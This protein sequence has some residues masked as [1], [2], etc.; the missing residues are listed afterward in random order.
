MTS[1][2]QFAKRL[3]EDLLP[4]F[5]RDERRN[6]SEDGFIGD[7]VRVTERD[8]ANFLYSLDAGLVTDRG[9]G[10]Y[11][12]PRSNAEETLFWTGPKNDARRKLWLWLEPVI[13]FG[14]LARLKRDF[15]WEADLLGTQS[16][17]WEFDFMAFK[18]EKLECE[19]I[20]GE[21]KRTV[22]EAIELEAHMFALASS[23]A[24]DPGSLT[25]RRRNAFRKLE[26][27]RRRKAA[28]FWIVGPDEYDRVFDVHYDDARG[29][30]LIRTTTERLHAHL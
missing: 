18:P 26:G 1:T 15:G 13:T 21:V 12:A 7:S 20:A 3:M 19:H 6:Y 10:R 25:G 27:L 23:I 8:A 22:A 30:T 24:V 17:K 5:C 28:L 11:W 29:V 9:G 2:T 4:A 14:T 16:A